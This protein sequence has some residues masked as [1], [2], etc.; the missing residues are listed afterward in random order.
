MGGSD[1]QA[2]DAPPHRVRS[3]GV[4]C[5]PEANTCLIPSTGRPKILGREESFSKHDQAG[6]CWEAGDGGTA[7]VRP[8]HPWMAG[9]IGCW[10][11]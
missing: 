9:D 8:F 6:M 1:L 2:V 10:Y 4:F 7:V 3:Q 11:L 5:S